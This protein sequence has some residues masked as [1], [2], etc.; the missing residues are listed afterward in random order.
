MG[1]QEPEKPKVSPE[2]SGVIDQHYYLSM[3]DE[4]FAEDDYEKALAFYSRTLQYDITMEE[5]WFG[6]LRCLIELGE[7]PEALTWSNR[8][9]EKFPK[10]AS[11][12]SARAVAEARSGRFGAAIGYSDSAFSSQGV[13]AY[14]WIARGEVLLLTSE[15][16]SKA[17]FA[18]AIEISSSEWSI[19]FWIARAY[20]I[21]KCYH[22]ALEHLNQAVKLDSGRFTCW[23]WIGKC[24]EALGQ[25][26]EAKIAYRRALAAKPSYIKAQDALR[27]IEERGPMSKLMSAIRR[28]FGAR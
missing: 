17:C 24:S 28:L 25:I 27:S 3:A 22:Q 20:I 9:L 5:G 6:Q 15:V 1:D 7:L 26:D 4:A 13:G 14:S 23:Y 18:K 2:Y 19:R 8:A 12:L 11:I 21:R 16:N 10:S